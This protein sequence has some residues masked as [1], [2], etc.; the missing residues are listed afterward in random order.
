M[1]KKGSRQQGLT[2]KKAV[3]DAAKTGRT[4]RS[5]DKTISRKKRTSV[6][7]RR[8]TTTTQKRDP[9]Y[10]RKSLPS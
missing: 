1:V 2:K 5:G 9:K 7:F 10:P 6:V 4:V 8:P 3:E